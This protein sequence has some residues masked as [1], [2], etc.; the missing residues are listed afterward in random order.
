MVERVPA[1]YEN[2]VT[3]TNSPEGF[4]PWSAT[5]M[6][7]EL[8]R[9]VSC[10]RIQITALPVVATGGKSHTD[11]FS[12]ICFSILMSTVFNRDINFL[13]DLVVGRYGTDV[14]LLRLFINYR[15]KDH[16]AE[17]KYNNYNPCETCR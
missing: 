7:F 11:D 8:P 3:P 16:Q 5:L 2:G 17:E 13:N 9:I 12:M 6:A 4:L 1:A 10:A 15:K 14:F